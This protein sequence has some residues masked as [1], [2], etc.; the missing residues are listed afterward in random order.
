MVWAAISWNS[1]DSIAALHCRISSKDYLNILGDHIH[2][3]VYAL[4]PDGDGIF[5]DDN[6]PKHIAHAWLRNSMKS[7]KVS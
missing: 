4:F 1:L 5:H 7:M 6:A 2:P 3:M